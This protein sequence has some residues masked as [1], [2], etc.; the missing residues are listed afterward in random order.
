MAHTPGLWKMDGEGFDSVSAAD[1][2]CEGYTVFSVDDEGCLLENICQIDET[3]EPE[4]AE[5]NAHLIAAAPDMLEALEYVKKHTHAI[6]QKP[7]Y[8]FVSATIAKAKGE[9]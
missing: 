5:A 2:G 7:I 8:D 6:Y 3:L 4:Q 9:E 1:Y